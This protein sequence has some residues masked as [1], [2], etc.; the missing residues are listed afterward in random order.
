MHS[1]EFLRYL[2]LDK[3]T[4]NITIR[5]ICFLC[6]QTTGKVLTKDCDIFMDARNGE[7][8]GPML[9]GALSMT[10]TTQV[11]RRD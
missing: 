4:L 5:N 6:V 9:A 7:V 1:E 11:L 3:W 2:L 10:P 8:S